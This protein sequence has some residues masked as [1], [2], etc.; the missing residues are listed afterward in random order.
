V[1]H[2]SRMAAVA[3]ML[4][5]AATGVAHARSVNYQDYNFHA[6]YTGRVYSSPSSVGS[7]GFVPG[8]GIVGESCDLPSSACS[9]NERVTG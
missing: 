1:F 9:N 6:G 5:F 2:N 7:Q 4:A 8:R 3:V